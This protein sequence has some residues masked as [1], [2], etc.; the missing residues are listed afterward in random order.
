[1]LSYSDDIKI[2]GTL[3]GSGVLRLGMLRGTYNRPGLNRFGWRRNIRNRMG[4]L[5]LPF[6]VGFSGADRRRCFELFF[7]IDL[8]NVFRILSR[9]GDD[10]Q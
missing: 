5:A 8:G 6:R 9:L 2:P 4:G 3:A 7:E 10:L 1:M